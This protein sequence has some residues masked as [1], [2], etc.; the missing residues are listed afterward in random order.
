MV[1]FGVGL[2]FLLKRV[3]LSGMVN[4]LDYSFSSFQMFIVG[5]QKDKANNALLSVLLAYIC[6]LKLSC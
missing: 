3:D 6:T 2:F 5:L 1:F 4:D